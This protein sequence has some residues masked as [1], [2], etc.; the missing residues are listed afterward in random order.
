MKKHM[1]PEMQAGIISGLSDLYT[2]NL[3][4]GFYVLFRIVGA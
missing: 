3:H 1:E 2:P 4:F